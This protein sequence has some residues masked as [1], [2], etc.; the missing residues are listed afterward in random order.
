MALVGRSGAGKTTLTDLVA[1]FHDPTR[2][3]ITVNGTDIR[4]FRLHSYR[5]LLGV[6]HQDVFLF[7][8]TVR[9]NI[10]YGRH[11]ATEAEIVDALR[12]ANALEFVTALPEGY[13]SLIGE[14]SAHTMNP[15]FVE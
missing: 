9:E 10:A 12:R 15:I 7:D 3:R 8:G 2:G 14:R 13:D 11:G 5:E 6:V 4:N 1:R